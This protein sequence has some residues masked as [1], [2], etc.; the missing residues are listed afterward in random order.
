M[1]SDVFF[2]V[3]SILRHVFE[4]L[5]SNL[6]RLMLDL[7]IQFLDVLH[8]FDFVLVREVQVDGR[9]GVLV[10]K[11]LL[12]V[13]ALVVAEEGASQLRVGVGASEVLG[14]SLCLSFGL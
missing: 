9:S 14:L 11:I 5:E 6:G 1:C 2:G 12:Y 7:F 4:M 10:L 8:S 13:L 3:E